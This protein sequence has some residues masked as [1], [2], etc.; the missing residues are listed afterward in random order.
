MDRTEHVIHATRSRAPRRSARTLS[1]ALASVA[2]AALLTSLCGCLPDD[3]EP[4][5]AK[6]LHNAARGKA[7]GDLSAGNALL[8]QQRLSKIPTTYQSRYE[9]GV[10]DRWN[11]KDN[12]TLD[13]TIR[14]SEME[15][16]GGSGRPLSDD[17]TVRLTLQDLVNRAVANNLDVRV[18][19]YG[20]AIEASRIIEAEARFDPTFF[21]N[22]GV[23]RTDRATPGSVV[24]DPSGTTLR[25]VRTFENKQDAFTLA[26]GIK[27]T[28]ETG[29]NIQVQQQLK[30]TSQ[31][32]T[33]TIYNPY[34]ESDLTLEITQ[35]LLRDFG[36]KVNRARI[37]I[38]RNTS[39]VSL[40]DF[41]KAA[42]DNLA[43]VEKVYWELHQA[44]QDVYIQERLVA[45]SRDT[46]EKIAVRAQQ[47]ATVSQMKQADATVQTRRAE[48]IRTRARVRDLS[49]QLKQLVNDP[50][51][52]VTSNILVL[53]ATPPLQEP[54]NLDT[55][56]I[57][58]SAL[59]N[60]LELGQQL[61]K[62][63]NADITLDAAKNNLLPQLNVKGTVN[64]NGTDRD[65]HDAFLQQ[66]DFNRLTASVGFQFEIPLG[67][68]EATAIYRRSLLQR[69]Q[70]LDQYR[71]LVEQVALDVKTQL[72]DVQ[73]SWQE[74]LATRLARI[75]QTE[76]LKAIVDR[77]ERMG[78]Y[79]PTSVQL[80]LDSQER[81]AQTARAEVASLA[82]YN[83]A[84]SKLEKAKGTLLR[85]N[86]VVIEEQGLRR[87][88]R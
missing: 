81:L 16:S 39:R 37:G 45:A 3:P 8:P 13:A 9:A 73:T 33:Q 35:P 74:V 56:D 32:P 27:Q 34:V 85:Y 29:A 53:P 88:L 40:L 47:D 72:R 1:A 19:G 21:T 25:S 24:T 78:E 2:A 5:N 55:D 87:Q 43:E 59:L 30:R 49:D 18:A 36:A 14:Q 23:E 58:G 7:T 51:M 41:R 60:R 61:L 12:P 50:D 22:L 83:T 20:P 64:P 66:S 63:D 86:N 17:K 28:L 15:G 10:G 6:A 82:N 71:S 52:P 67:N 4:Y 69:Y 75:A 68:R 54:V 65:V 48:L 42:E 70:A 31:T 11:P 26:S 76:S 46:A 38:A 84:I 57:I 80:E 62:L 79:S 77:R 44:E